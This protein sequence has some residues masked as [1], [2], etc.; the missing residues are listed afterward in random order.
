MTAWTYLLLCSDG[1][2]YAGCTTDLERRLAQ[3]EAGSHDGYTSTRRPLKLVWTGEFQTVLDAIDMER[4]I[5]RW[6]RLKKEAL[7]RRDY[8]TLPDFSGRGFRPSDAGNR[9]SSSLRSRRRRSLE[10]RTESL[11][12][13]RRGL[14][15]LI[16]MTAQK[17]LWAR[18]GCNAFS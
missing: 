3:H 2:Y 9:S 15:P 8:D 7:A 17:R 6:S 11:R 10:G 12:G 1:S 5:K 13:S 18:Y 16:T 14:R 4:R